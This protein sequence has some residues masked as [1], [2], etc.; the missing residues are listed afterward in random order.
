MEYPTGFRS[1]ANYQRNRTGAARWPGNPVNLTA[2]FKRPRPRAR[3]AFKVN[4]RSC[5]L[6]NCIRRFIRMRLGSIGHHG[7]LS[8][9]DFALRDLSARTSHV[10][11]EI[12]WEK[13][14]LL[15]L[16][17]PPCCVPGRIWAATRIAD[18]G[19]GRCRPWANLHPELA[20]YPVWIV[21]RPS[22]VPS[23][24]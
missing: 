9:R 7:R 10:L 13:I 5:P 17:P 16:T 14:L 18:E 23:M 21:Y 8:I 6:R 12:T 15:V 2:G 11:V 3:I 4:P 1:G 19:P 22:V 20:R 24:S